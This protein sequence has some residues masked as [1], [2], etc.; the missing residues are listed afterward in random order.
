MEYK[1]FKEFVQKF[2]VE[3]KDYISGSEKIV[4]TPESIQ[5]VLN[6]YVD[7]YIEGTE[8]SFAEKLEIQFRYAS[9]EAKIVF[10][11]ASWLYTLGTSAMTST[12]KINAVNMSLVGLPNYRLRTDIFLD[13]KGIANPGTG[14]GGMKYLNI[15]FPLFVFK[16]VKKS[17]AGIE[18]NSIIKAIINACLYAKYENKSYLEKSFGPEKTHGIVED[19][20]VF[21]TKSG[22]MP[23]LGIYNF[24]LN[25]CDPDYYERIVSSE[26]KRQI[27]E[28]AFKTVYIEGENIRL[29]DMNDDDKIYYVA[30]HFKAI[31]PDLDERSILRDPRIMRLWQDDKND[32]PQNSSTYSQR[33]KNGNTNYWL[34]QCNPRFYNI[35]G[36]LNTGL[37]IN[38]RVVAHRERIK[39]GDKVILWASGT[40]A[41]C[42]AL[43]EVTSVVRTATSYEW[44]KEFWIGN[45]DENPEPMV[46]LTITHN[47]A[48]KPILKHQVAGIQDLE[49]LNVGLQGTNFNATQKQYEALEKI[50]Q[51]IL[52]IT[53]HSFP[54]KESNPNT[55]DNFTKPAKSITNL[56]HILYGP[57]GTGKTYKSIE[58][59]VQ[60][61]DPEFLQTKRNRKQITD[62]YKK[63]V[64]AGR[65]VFTTFH[66]SMS[67]EDFI[68][69]IKPLTQDNGQL[70][71][72]VMDGLFKK[73]NTMAMYNL[74]RHVQA[75]DT[76]IQADDFEYVYNKLLSDIEENKGE[77]PYE[78][79]TKSETI[80]QLVDI[81][82]NDNLQVK[83]K[84]STG[85]LT[86]IVSK[87]R[88]FKLYKA[89]DSIERIINVYNDIRQ[90]IRGANTSAYYAVLRKL[91]EIRGASQ[92][93]KL[94][95]PPPGHIDYDLMKV[96]L[97]TFTLP[98]TWGTT[99]QELN[100]ENFVIIIDEINR[101]NVS[102]IFGELITLVEADKRAGQLE[103]LRVTLPYSGESFCVAPNL[104]IIGTMNT[105][106]RSVEALDT[107]LRRRFAFE[108]IAPLYEIYDDNGND[109]MERELCGY[110]MKDI[111][112][113]LN[114]RIK[115]LL[116]KDH[117]IGHSY[118]LGLEK[119]EDLM[120]S[121]NRKIIPL[122]QEYFYGDYAKI[123]LVLGEGFVKSEDLGEK[124]L[125]SFGYDEADSLIKENYQ[126]VMHEDIA[127]FRAALASMME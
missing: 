27:A 10:A 77:L 67:Y 32:K 74:Y 14:Y 29:Q 126:L 56:N 4:L 84:D 45:Y 111:L 15:L 31:Y 19:C 101:G 68:E 11:H 115:I 65:I 20:K 90:I 16:W 38:W 82:S 57:P 70:Q 112:K 55:N 18:Q 78:F 47:L 33:S 116:D 69:G 1:L 62:R 106:D 108:E 26:E 34:F 22:N 123:G 60:I 37:P 107:A 5:E 110:Q 71:Y 63:L 121:F 96:S 104:Y 28:K 88:L 103:A 86:Y 59:A 40:N 124:D 58:L 114:K 95:S 72:D 76:A 91:Y 53:D 54:N 64:D 97:E 24:L 3:R 42:Y 17:Q 100:N 80:I 25:L 99:A 41:G 8:Q 102:Q 94:V 92:R 87:D 122:L 98:E 2:L 105:A 52:N 125:A 50:A 113:T 9:E 61:A 23:K 73:I 109:V 93:S 46:E 119:D 39:Y 13:R 79:I 43:A 49:E 6:L 30:K 117:Q 12:G 51:S 118:F 81:S 66:Q 7:N 75:I 21:M 83:H 85:T 89:Y 48:R 120:E 44:E 127:E 35:V 36:A